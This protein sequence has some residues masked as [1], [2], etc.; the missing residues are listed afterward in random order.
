MEFLQ[1]QYYTSAR[2]FY[3]LTERRFI[4]MGLKVC[5]FYSSGYYRLTSMHANVYL[6]LK[7]HVTTL[8]RKANTDVNVSEEWSE[9]RE[10]A[11]GYFP[12]LFYIVLIYNAFGCVSKCTVASLALHRDIA[13]A[14]LKTLCLI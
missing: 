7:Q 9:H 3:V 2:A 13:V 12:I 14:T 8:H 10:R 1:C 11:W 4:F 6:H 5:T